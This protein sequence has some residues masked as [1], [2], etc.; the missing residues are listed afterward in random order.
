MKL[1]DT[2]REPGSGTQDDQTSADQSTATLQ[3]RLSIHLLAVFRKDKKKEI[4]KNAEGGNRNRA[5]KTRRGGGYYTNTHTHTHTHECA[6]E[7][8]K[9]TNNLSAR[10]SE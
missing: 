2:G 8:Q 9:K 7:E 1:L 6:K 3:S 4:K 10:K 5:K